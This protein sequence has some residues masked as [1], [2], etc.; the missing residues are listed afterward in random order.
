MQKGDI[1]FINN[2]GLL[3]GREGFNDDTEQ[4]SKRHLMRLW[5]RNSKLQWSLPPELRLVWGRIFDDKERSVQWLTEPYIDQGKW[6][7][8]G[9]RSECD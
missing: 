2:M 6:I 3:H 7:G 9:L 8:R 4:E 5:L 1:R